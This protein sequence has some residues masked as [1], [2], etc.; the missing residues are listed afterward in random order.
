M[1]FKNK[2]M[3]VIAYANGWTLWHYKTNQDTLQDIIDNREY[4]SNLYTLMN[5]GDVVYMETK[6]RIISQVAVI[7]VGEKFVELKELKNV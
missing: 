1:A 6:D 3:S 5:V 7:R 2:D 4:F